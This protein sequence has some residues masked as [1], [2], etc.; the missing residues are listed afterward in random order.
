MLKKTKVEGIF[1]GEQ[2]FVNHNINI[3][4]RGKEVRGLTILMNDVK[5][6][7]SYHI[8]HMKKIFESKD[9][10]FLF[11]SSYPS[12]SYLDRFIGSISFSLPPYIP[13]IGIVEGTDMVR[14]FILISDTPFKFFVSQPLI[15]L[16]RINRAKLNEMEMMISKNVPVF[17][18]E[19]RKKDK[20]T[21]LSPVTKDF[22]ESSG[23]KF[24]FTSGR[25]YFK[26]SLEKNLRSLKRGIIFVDK[27]FKNYIL[28]LPGFVFVSVPGIFIANMGKFRGYYPGLICGLE[29]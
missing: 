8:E 17:S 23:E 4:I 18:G 20:L 14:N 3:F 10:H 2:I 9:K 29:V 11:L 26:V 15:P 13:V 16:F 21:K 28:N 12:M 25:H 24:L 19:T 22:L 5:V 1:M 27:A 6:Q 7:R